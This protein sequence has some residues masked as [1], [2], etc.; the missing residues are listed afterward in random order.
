MK[1]TARTGRKHFKPLPKHVAVE[2]ATLVK[3]P[4]AGDRWLHEIKFDG[5]RLLAFVETATCDWQRAT[6]STGP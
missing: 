6:T 1:K 3:E 2:L 5:Y 4:P